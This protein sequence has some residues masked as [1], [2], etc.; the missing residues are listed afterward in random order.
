M[1][2]ALIP[3]FLMA[4]TGVGAGDLLT[5]SLAGYSMGMG[6]LWAPIIGAVMKYTLTLS[7]AKYQ[8][9]YDQTLVQ[10]WIE[11]LP[12]FFSI[13]FLIYLVLW[14]F[15]VAGAIIN[16][17]GASLNSIFYLG[18]SGKAIWAIIQAIIVLGI[19]LKGSFDFFSK[20]MTI[21]V[22]IMFVSV[23]AMSAF[24]IQ[25]PVSLLSS[26]IPHTNQLNDPWLI[27]VL[28]G[29]GGTLTIL[30]Y[31]YWIRELKLNNNDIAQVKT[32]LKVSYFLTALFSISMIILG[33]SLTQASGDKAN[34]I[35]E[36]SNMIK[37]KFGAIG[38]ITFQIGFWAGIFSSMLGVW[39]SVPSIFADAIDKFSTRSFDKEKLRQ[40]FLLYM[41]I[42]PLSSLWIKFESVQKMYSVLGACFIPLCAIVALILCWRNQKEGL[43]NS[44]IEKLIL[45]LCII[46]FAGIGLSKFL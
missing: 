19:A 12:R 27:G 15:T 14:S 20:L 36:L 1:I 17:A 11:K 42:L 9:E 23:I 3:G 30:S 2:K 38:I 35:M 44:V 43:N 8:L 46:C 5:G 13:V 16:G 32:D 10:G 31:G 33:A 28:G 39:Q 26:F 24:F 25:S 41:G 22:F 34:I 18:D 29:V 6:I 21:L 37:A 40:Y 4:A 7:I 45:G